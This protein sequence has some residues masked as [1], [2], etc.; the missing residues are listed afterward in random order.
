[1]RSIQARLDLLRGEL[2]HAVQWAE[3][4][5][6]GEL[7]D[8]PFNFEVQGITWSR[9]HIAQ[10]TSSSLAAATQYLN[11]ILAKAEG[12][13]NIRWLISTLAHL[14]VAY[15]DQGQISDALEALERSVK[16]AKPGGFVRTFVELGEDMSFMLRQL[17]NQ[18]IEVQ[19][20]NRILSGFYLSKS[21]KLTMKD[22]PVEIIF[23]S[24][25]NILPDPLTRRECEILLQLSERRTNKEIAENLNIS[26]LTV[27]KHTSKVF[28]KLGVKTRIQAVDKAKELGLLLTG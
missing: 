2:H 28:Q 15:K 20:I 19:Y 9:I 27:K 7:R 6:I 25:K 12:S 11:I 8:S 13:N 21:T 1:M 10:G 4:V 5:N 18:G 16:L 17:V 22:E 23:E 26:I 24:S 14:A 3:S